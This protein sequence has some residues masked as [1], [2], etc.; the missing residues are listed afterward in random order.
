MSIRVDNSG[1]TTYQ[2]GN[3]LTSSAGGILAV[4]AGTG[5]SVSADAVAV[6]TAAALTWTAQQTFSSGLL[7][8]AGS[9][10][11]PSVGFSGDTNTGMYSPGADQWAIATN[12]AQ[13]FLINV[14]TVTFANVSTFTITQQAQTSGTPTATTITGGAHTGLTASTEVADLNINLNRTVQWA[15]GA[16]T[17]QRAILIQ[18][19]TY[20]FVGA[21]TITNASTVYISG[22]PT[23]GTNA[24][25]TNAYSLF[26]DAGLVRFDGNGTR[27]FELPADATGNST[28]ATGRVP[29]LVGGVTKYLRYF[30]D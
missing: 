2:A 18:A 8:S 30:D 21:S 15:T 23:A 5:I 1:V 4:G 16:I 27:V 25:I 3:G 14:N 12:G 6:D 13:R 20:A 19:P 29:I 24:T 26:V 17:N 9:A 7:A 11:A 28:A 10:S 22:A